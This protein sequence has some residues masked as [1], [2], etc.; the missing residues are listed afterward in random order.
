LNNIVQGFCRDLLADAMLQMDDVVLHTHD[1]IV[2]EVYQVVADMVK[3]QMERVMNTPPAWAA[4]FPLHA[5]CT[6]M[7]RYG[8]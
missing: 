4:G 3:A 2:Q 5:K 1:E 6:V 7:T 8:K